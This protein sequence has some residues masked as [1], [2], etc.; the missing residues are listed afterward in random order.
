M[1]NLILPLKISFVIFLLPMSVL[2]QMLGFE[3]FYKREEKKYPPPYYFVHFND[4]L[5]KKTLKSRKIKY[6]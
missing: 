2:K 6:F 1:I 3:K 4:P 5:M